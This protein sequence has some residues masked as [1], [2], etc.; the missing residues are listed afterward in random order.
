MLLQ[1]AHLIPALCCLGYVYG[2]SPI[3][4]L[5]ALG[6]LAWPAAILASMLAT[7]A[8]VAGTPRFMSTCKSI[9]SPVASNH[10]T[11]GKR[12]EQM[13]FFAGNTQDLCV[14]VDWLACHHLIDMADVGFDSKKATTCRNIGVINARLPHDFICGIEKHSR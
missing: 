1:I 13:H 2:V 12:M 4:L 8:D 5:A 6:R 14:N 10:L 3:A 9:C 7:V 11:D